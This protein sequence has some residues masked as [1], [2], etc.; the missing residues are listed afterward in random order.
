MEIAA[1]FRVIS[2]T[3]EVPATH[4]DI[5]KDE[6]YDGVIMTLSKMI[7]RTL[8]QIEKILDNEKKKMVSF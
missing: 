6:I 8:S 2:T 5:L 1:V 4:Y 3:K 7:H